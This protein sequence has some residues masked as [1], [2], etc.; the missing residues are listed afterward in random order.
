MAVPHVFVRCKNAAS[1]TVVDKTQGRINELFDQANRDID[2]ANTMAQCNDRNE[3]FAKKT[4]SN[5][6]NNHTGEHP[7]QA[8]RL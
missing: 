3:N 8:Q 6:R 4:S 7:M 1:G 5:G 2:G